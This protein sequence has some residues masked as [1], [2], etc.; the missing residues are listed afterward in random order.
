MEMKCRHSIQESTALKCKTGHK[1]RKMRIFYGKTPMKLPS[2]LQKQDRLG[3]Q[4]IKR[5]HS[6]KQST[7]KT[8][9]ARQGLRP[10]PGR[11]KS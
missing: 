1:R 4:F 7:E 10:A 6:I 2:F 5:T 3:F 11:R 9:S 8:I